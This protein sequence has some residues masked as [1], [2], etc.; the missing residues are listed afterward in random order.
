MICPKSSEFAKKINS[1]QKSLTMSIPSY[2]TI[3]LIFISNEKNN[4]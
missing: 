1:R 2:S 3:Q 4:N